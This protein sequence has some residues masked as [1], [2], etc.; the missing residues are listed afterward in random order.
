MNPDTEILKKINSWDDY[1]SYSNQLTKHEK[2]NLFER[3]TELILLTKPEYVSLIK[4]VWRQGK[5][6]PEEVRNYLNLPKTD[7]G[8]DLIAETHLGEY[9]AIQCKFKGDNT[10]PTYKEL[11]TFG[12]LSNNYCKNISRSFLFHT[13]EKGVLK[14]KLLGET[15]NQVGL[16]FWLSL[17]QE[18]WERIRNKVSGKLVRPQP[19]LPR[20]HQ[21]KAIKSAREHFITKGENRGKLIMPCGTGKSL[22]AFWVADSLKSKTIVVAVPSLS[23]IKQTLEDWT[24]ELIAT[25]KNHPEWLCICSDESTGKLEKDEFV[26]DVYSLGIPTTTNVDVIKGFLER[27]TKGKK[28]VFTTYQSSER[29]AQ[30]AKSLKF[31]FDL[32][33]LDE[34]HKTVGEKSKTFATLLLDKNIKIK[35]R[36]FMTATE[37]VVS[38]KNDDILSMDDKSIYGD[39]FYLLTFKEAIHSDPPII[40]DYKVLTV[41]VTN[42]EIKELISENKLITDNKNL[43]EEKESL[44]LASAVALRKCYNQYGIRH[45]VSFHSSIKRAEEFKNLNETLT[46]SGVFKNLKSYHISSKKSAGE[47]S[48]LIRDFAREQSSLITNAR[49]LTEGVDV[50]SIDCVLFADPKQSLVDIV[51]AVGRALRISKDKKFGYILLPIIVPDG[52][53]IEEFASSTPYRQIVRIITALSTQ[54]ERIAEEFRLSTSNKKPKTDRIIN[55]IGSIPISINLTTKDFINQIETKIWSVVGRANWRNFDDAREFV[56]MLNF[57]SWSD[58]KAY[59]LTG[60]K[61]YDIPSDPSNVYKGIGWISVGDWIGTNS[62]STNNRNYRNFIDARNYVHSLKLKNSAEWK[63]YIKSNNRPLDI[64]S[65][66]NRVYNNKGWISLGDWLG[67]YQSATFQRKF[68]DFYEAREFVRSLNLIDGKEWKR[69]CK[70]GSKPDDIPTNPNRTYKNQGWVSIGDWLGTFSTADSKRY[71]RPFEDARNYVRKLSL[72][73]TKDWKS[74]CTS[75]LKPEDIPT[76]PYRTYEKSGWINM[77]D[78]LG[79]EIIASY[80]KKY[81]QFE[82]AREF[83]QSLKLLNQKEWFI[84]CKSEEKPDYIS[85]TPHTTYKN[86]GW[87]SYGDWLGTGRIANHKISFRKFNDARKYVHTLKLKTKDEWLRFVKSEEKPNDVPSKPSASYKNKGWVSWGDWLGTG[88]IAN[89]NISYRKFNDARKYVHTLKLKTWAEWLRYVKSGEKPNDIPSK[90]NASYKNKG[91]ISMGDWLGNQS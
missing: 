12:N 79:V 78:W 9:W 80:N 64:P 53:D 67:S 85:S 48:S 40:S 87:V 15:F 46:R 38:S 74:Y 6:V 13:G 31:E 18:D 58:W 43:Y 68:R 24:K 36:V 45:T 3:L 52:M 82:N 75:G 66:P 10:P 16:E 11:S 29:L 34:A 20:P 54:D 63:Q 62:I 23:L 37:R 7:E 72:K 59:L 65:N 70:S 89:Y 19:R 30:V 69:Y 56:Q 33:I 28:I 81:L 77:G 26:S 73:S 91:W 39:R 8:I 84:Y 50:P 76:K 47:R 88:R 35:K 17:Q 51:Q 25:S 14:K 90:P 49:C 22:T 44:S 5:N 71:Y 32:G 4:N 41:M 55:T 2:G 57:K 86:K 1:W 27:K 83:A 60:L 61:P 42:E 21:Q